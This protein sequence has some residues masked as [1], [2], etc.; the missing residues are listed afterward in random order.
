MGLL[1]VLLLGGL[2]MAGLSGDD[3]DA[4]PAEAEPDEI[5]GTEAGVEI[6][7]GGETV[8]LVRG[9]SVAEV[10]PMLTIRLLNGDAAA[11]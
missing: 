4:T 2:L 1:L 9:A 10:D 5:R 8:M 6:V 3:D 7:M 11:A